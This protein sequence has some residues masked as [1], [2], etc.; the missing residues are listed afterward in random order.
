M[1]LPYPS[2]P[3][4]T[5]TITTILSN[6]RDNLSYIDSNLGA[7]FKIVSFTK[8]LAVGSEAKN[9]VGVG[10]TPRTILF[11]SAEP[12]Q[13]LRCWG[14][15]GS[16]TGYENNCLYVYSDGTSLIYTIASNQIGI[17][18][19]GV[20]LSRHITFCSVTSVNNDG[21]DLLFI[22]SGAAGVGTV[23]GYAFCIK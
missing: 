20:D 4:I 23:T 17:F 14:V 10:F 18:R 8:D 11:Y 16:S 6:T 2:K 19:Y 22:K 21:F 7:G 5:D 3:S 9:V 1:T 13:S 12:T 15:Y